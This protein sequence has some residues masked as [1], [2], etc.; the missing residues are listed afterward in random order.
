[1]SGIRG[2]GD[3]RREVVIV[4]NNNHHLGRNLLQP[5]T[6]MKVKLKEP[7]MCLAQ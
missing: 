2:S 3:Y 1:M 5:S 4:I 6:S 7:M